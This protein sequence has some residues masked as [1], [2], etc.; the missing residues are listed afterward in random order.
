MDEQ[1]C[2]LSFSHLYGT[3]CVRRAGLTLTI[4]PL[5]FPFSP[6]PNIH[7]QGVQRELTV[8][9]TLHTP[10]SILD[11]RHRQ[12][13]SLPVQ[14]VL[15][16]YAGTRPDASLLSR[17]GSLAVWHSST[18]AL[19]QIPCD[20]WLVGFLSLVV[21]LTINCSEPSLSF[22]L[23]RRTTSLA[24]KPITHG[25]RSSCFLVAVFQIPISSFI[26]SPVRWPICSHRSSCKLCMARLM[27]ASPARSLSLQIKL[28]FIFRIIYF[29]PPH[30]NGL[31]R[32]VVLR[33]GNLCKVSYPKMPSSPRR[34]GIGMY[35]LGGITGFVP[36]QNIYRVVDSTP[37]GPVSSALIDRR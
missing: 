14:N 37:L 15:P 28:V 13:G 6:S 34:H 24:S 23:R 4:S 30:R 1:I 10:Y 3:L 33:I 20:C 19:W 27:T 22:C 11:T 36:H 29:E 25:L 9:L 31:L 26:L 8:K 18:L 32:A 17:P 21:S 2:T 12:C 16:D 7:K 35:C 5:V